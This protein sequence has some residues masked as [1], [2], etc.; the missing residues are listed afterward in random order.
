VSITGVGVSLNSEDA[1]KVPNAIHAHIFDRPNDPE[2]A[3]EAKH[4]CPVPKNS[5]KFR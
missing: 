3:S 2:S 1:E 4:F 5:A